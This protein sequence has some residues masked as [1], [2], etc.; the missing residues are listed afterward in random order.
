MSLHRLYREELEILYGSFFFH[1]FMTA[2]DHETCTA[3]NQD[4]CF[5]LFA[6]SLKGPPRVL[7]GSGLLQRTLFAARRSCMLV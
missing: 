2:E 5:A 1:D 7:C 4:R 3:A 6:F